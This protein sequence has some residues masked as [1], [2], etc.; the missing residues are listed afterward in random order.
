MFFFFC[1]F[2]NSLFKTSEKRLILRKG[3]RISIFFTGLKSE[4]NPLVYDFSFHDSLCESGIIGKKKQTYSENLIGDISIKL[5]FDI[6]FPQD[7]ESDCFCGHNLT[8]LQVRYINSLILDNYI[9]TFNLD[10]KK[11]LKLST[12]TEKGLKVGT[13]NGIYNTFT[14]FINYRQLNKTEETYEIL[15]LTGEETS[16]LYEYTANNSDFCSPVKR[17][18]QTLQDNQLLMFKFNVK[19]KKIKDTNQYDLEAVP[20]AADIHKNIILLIIINIIILVSIILVASS[21]C[22]K[23]QTNTLDEEIEESIWYFLRGDIFR[24]PK[25]IHFLCTFFGAG[26]QVC[27]GLIITSLLCTFHTYSD[28]LSLFLNVF[29]WLGFFGGFA[30]MKLFKKIGGFEWRSVFKAT[31]SLIPCIHFLLFSIRSFIYFCFDS[32]GSPT[33]RTVIHVIY[34]CCVHCITDAIGMYIGLKLIL[35]TTWFKV[36]MIPKQ[37]PLQ[38]FYLSKLM[39]FSI[40]GLYMFINLHRII[41]FLFQNLWNEQL[42]SGYKT[43]VIYF[44][45]LL[46]ILSAEVSIFFVY[47]QVKKDN[48]KWWWTSFGCSSSIGLVVFLYSLYFFKS[49]THLNPSFSSLTLFLSDS[50]FYSFLMALCCGMLGLASTLIFLMRVYSRFLI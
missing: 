2:S 7:F 37:I 49:S 40:S 24:P 9:Y 19:F 13:T 39:I 18:S 14:F 38:P 15:S 36:N 21:D 28:I 41:V 23:A 30:A 8:E 20:I 43:T 12:E 47:I 31:I 10:N 46:C 32:T 3:E 42:F 4:F 29:S 45:L 25:T 1:S 34:L 11:M 50:F 22:F 44:V 6:H 16:V 26:I 35:D 5:P 33:L 27:L 48:Y 17:K